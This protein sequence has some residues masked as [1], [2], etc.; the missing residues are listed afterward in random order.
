MR[1]LVNYH[2]RE[3]C[4]E[5]IRTLVDINQQREILK[6]EDLAYVGKQPRGRLK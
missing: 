4:P 1:S 6:V 5:W 3:R 2:A